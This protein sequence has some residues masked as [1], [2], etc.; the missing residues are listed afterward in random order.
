[1][2]Q[3]EQREIAK[4][5]IKIKKS[6]RREAWQTGTVLVEE[7]LHGIFKTR[8]GKQEQSLALDLEG[9]GPPW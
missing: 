8:A 9:T 3:Q 2:R 4:R 1:M 6:E 5:L 7:A